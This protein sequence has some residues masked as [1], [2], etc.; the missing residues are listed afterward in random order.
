MTFYLVTF[1]CM[2]V[3]YCENAH[4]KMY[5]LGH[6]VLG[7]F[8]FGTALNDQCLTHF[9]SYQ[10]SCSC[11]HTPPQSCWQNCFSGVLQ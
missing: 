11:C 9:C 6:L 2:C 10:A 7:T 8:H 3:F 4:N 1:L 5:L